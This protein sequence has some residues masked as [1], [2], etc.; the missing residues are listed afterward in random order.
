MEVYNK[1]VE[2]CKKL[3]D[4]TFAKAIDILSKKMILMT[5]KRL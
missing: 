2:Y 1:M 3:D 4:D 5:L